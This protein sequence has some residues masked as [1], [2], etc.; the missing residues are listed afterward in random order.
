MVSKVTRSV[1]CLVLIL[2]MFEMT[3][4]AANKDRIGTAGAQELLI[5]VGARGMA[6]GPS[7]MVFSQGVEAIYWNP[8]GLSRIDHGVEAM[9]SQMTYIADINVTYAAIGVNA[10]EFGTLGFSL[11]SLSFGNIPVTTENFPDGTGEQ[12][13]PTFMNLG[14]TYSKLLT[15][16]I[17]VGITG[18]LISEKILSTSASGLAF[19]VGIQ[20]QNLGV[21]GLNL[22]VAVRNIGPN[23]KFDGSNLYRVATPQDGIRG[24]GFYKVE[25]AGFE[26][27]SAMEIGIGYTRKFDEKNSFQVGGT[28]RNNNYQD[29]EYNLGGEYNFNNL[30]FLRGGYTFAPQAEKDLLNSNKS[31]YLYDYTLGAGLHT[32]VGGVSIAFDYAYRH[33]KFFDGNNVITLRLGF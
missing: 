13:S 8:A 19:N 33:V 26:L 6:L 12:Y 28:F 5:P 25:S 18:T 7:S 3:A 17:A 2:G 31:T 27:P 21:Q 9:L 32:D 4:E 15:D 30:F 10:G 16:R 29:D 23:M 20:Y 11:K 24:S 1:V 14:V 22:G